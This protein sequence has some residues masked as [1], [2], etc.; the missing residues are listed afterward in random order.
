LHLLSRSGQRREPQ[1]EGGNKRKF[2]ILTVE[3]KEEGFS[4][5][6]GVYWGKVCSQGFVR[7]RGL[8]ERV[9]WFA[10]RKDL[11]SIDRRGLMAFHAEK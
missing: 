4:E 10:K 11:R 6:R 2:D 9:T 5:E 1:G 3:M 7:Q 8:T